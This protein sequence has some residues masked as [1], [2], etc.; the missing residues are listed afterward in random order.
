MKD[1][2]IT[3]KVDPQTLENVN[4]ICEMYGLNKSEFIRCCIKRLIDNPE[5]FLK[6]LGFQK[7]TKEVWVSPFP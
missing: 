5:E 6:K 2:T 1:T 3:S 4:K 7:K